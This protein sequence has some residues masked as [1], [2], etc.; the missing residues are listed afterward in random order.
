VALAKVP[1]ASLLLAVEVPAF[2][3]ELADFA[4][5]DPAA[6]SARAVG[7]RI[8]NMGGKGGKG[9]RRRSSAMN[10]KKS[11]RSVGLVALATSRASATKRAS[12][13]V[14]GGEAGSTSAGPAAP[15]CTGW[16]SL[17]GKVREEAEAQLG[18][19]EATAATAA[20]GHLFTWLAHVLG[21]IVHLVDL[22]VEMRP[23]IDNAASTLLDADLSLTRRR[24]ELNTA[25]KAEE[26]HVLAHDKYMAAKRIAE[27]ATLANEHASKAEASQ[28]ERAG[29]AASAD[30]PG[31][32]LPERRAFPWSSLDKRNK[33][34]RVASF[35]RKNL[36]REQEIRVQATRD[37][38]A[39]LQ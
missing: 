33:G 23:I 27:T 12:V 6:S 11:L 29:A 21:G 36:E 25:R 18:L 14:E 28:L 8:A 15:P 38:G 17:R 3:A 24:K 10:A 2:I 7:E 13:L 34:A 19:A 30:E 39:L 20:T 35:R 1:L 31:A 5:A 9:V 26:D 22:E 32:S 37:A 16:D 4:T